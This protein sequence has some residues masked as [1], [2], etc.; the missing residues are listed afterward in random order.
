MTTRRPRLT[1]SAILLGVTL[2]IGYPTT[3]ASAQVAL[4]PI[5]DVPSVVG[6]GLVDLLTTVTGAVYGL[7]GSPAWEVNFKGRATLL[8]TGTEAMVI[9]GDYTCSG[10][11]LPVAGLDGPRTF[12]VYVTQ[13]FRDD[14]PGSAITKGYRKRSTPICNGKP[15]EFSVI[16]TA[17]YGQFAFQR[18]ATAVVE[19]VITV[20]DLRGCSRGSVV[21]G[22]NVV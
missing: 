12:E 8:G 13:S 9:T 5:P 4:P 7:L 3:P 2:A 17:D 10:L 20:C 18:Q 22:V 15:H 11:F 6:T 21:G 1:A 19:M 14:K 16:V